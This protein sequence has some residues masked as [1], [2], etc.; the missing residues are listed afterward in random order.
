MSIQ[1]NINDILKE[2]VQDYLA[3]AKIIELH[4]E[5]QE[6]FFGDPI[7][8]IWVVYESENNRLDPDKVS[9]VINPLRNRINKTTNGLD[10]FPIISF[11]TSKEAGL[12]TN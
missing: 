1:E 5:E 9:N 12:A 6:D 8:R 2:M 4:S 10:R 7:M 11:M 3:P